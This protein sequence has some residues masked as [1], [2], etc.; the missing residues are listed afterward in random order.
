MSNTNNSNFHWQ[1][2]SSRLTLFLDS[3]D[4]KQLW[5]KIT[6]TAPEKR[7]ER[8]KED[9]L[10]EEG[11]WEDINLS[12][13]V[14]SNRIDIVLSSIFTPPELP[15]AGNIKDIIPKIKGIIDTLLIDEI[16]RI[17]FGLVVIQPEQDH[18]KAYKSLSKLLPNVDIEEETTDFLYQVNLPTQSKTDSPF[19][20]NSLRRY[21]V[22]LFQFKS[23]SAQ[24]NDVDSINSYATKLELDINTSQSTDLDNTLNNKCII[25]ELIAEAIA[26]T[27][28]KKHA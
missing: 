17:A 19:E 24:T 8:P 4:Q 18:P 15:N 2:E 21:S 23:I 13:S 5:E 7:T 12:V 6:G 26:I 3:S 11:E 28:G 14:S 10:I 20:I 25:D 9:L 22:I 16:K 27:E 1:V